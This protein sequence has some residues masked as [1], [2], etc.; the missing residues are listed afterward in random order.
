[1]LLPRPRQERWGRTVIGNNNFYPIP[2]AVLTILGCTQRWGGKVAPLLADV[3][4]N[5]TS[6][7]SKNVRKSDQFP[8]FTTAEAARSTAGQDSLVALQQADGRRRRRLG[9]EIHRVPRPPSGSGV[10]DFAGGLSAV[11]IR[12]RRERNT[13]CHSFA[14]NIPP[15]P[16]FGALLCKPCAW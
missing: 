4:I 15:T 7:Q 16:R 9:H 5:P 12:N 6:D 13:D 2:L 11:R 3:I 8:N 14:G 10:R 1:M